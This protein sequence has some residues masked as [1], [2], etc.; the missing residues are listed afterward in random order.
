MKSGYKQA[1]G[2]QLEMRGIP[3]II[4][5][6]LFF[7]MIGAFFLSGTGCSPLE[8][9]TPATSTPSIALTST[10]T[11]TPSITPSAVP[12]HTATPLAT[13]TP[14]PPQPPSDVIA[15]SKCYNWQWN[16]KIRLDIY[17]RWQDNASDELGYSIYKNGV[18]IQTAPPNT[19]EYMEIQNTTSRNMS[20]SDVYAISAWNDAGESEQVE[21]GANFVCHR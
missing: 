10:S 20:V 16:W 15:D 6:I 11:H 18:L 3:G 14:A 12:I 13:P 5:G 2:A 17:L 9:E 1:A 8:G 7:C 21:V 19:T 4:Q